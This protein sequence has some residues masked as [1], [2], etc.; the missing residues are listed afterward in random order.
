[1][2][3]TGSQTL[4]VEMS[5]HSGQFGEKAILQRAQGT[6]WPSASNYSLMHGSICPSSS[7]TTSQTSP[8][9]VKFLS[10][11]IENDAQDVNTLD[12]PNKTPAGYICPRT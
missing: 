4:L 7:D 11:N 10:V 12:G 5:E 2:S 9:Q 6:L 3:L 8:H 1:M